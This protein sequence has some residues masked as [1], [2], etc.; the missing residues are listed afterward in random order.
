MGDEVYHIRCPY[1]E[2]GDCD[3]V[4]PLAHSD[5]NCC[6]VRCGIVH[7]RGEER[8]LPKHGTRAEV[9]RY[10]FPDGIDWPGTVIGCGR[11]FHFPDPANLEPG[12]TYDGMFLSWNDEIHG[13]LA[14][15]LS[16]DPDGDYSRVAT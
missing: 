6:K 11:P 10:L 2:L 15:V 1:H 9:E 5:L 8:Q 7:W 14:D 12:N 3:R 16:S 13:T 4:W